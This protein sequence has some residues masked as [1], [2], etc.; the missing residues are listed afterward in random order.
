MA[1]LNPQNEQFDRTSGVTTPYWID[2][3]EAKFTAKP[4]SENMKVDVCIVGGGIAGIT[5]AYLL[6]KAG[7]RV[8]LLEDGQIG[9][10]ETG[11]TTA[12][13]SSVI[14]SGF[15][16]IKRIHGL[17]K[18]RLAAQSHAEAINTIE[19]IVREEHIDCEFKRVDGY[20]FQDKSQPSHLLQEEF[21]AA[22][23]ADMKDAQLI[24][25]IP[26]PDFAT[27]SAIHFP[28]QAQFHPM[29][30]LDALAHVVTDT[31]KAA[32]YTNTRALELSE[33]QGL[34]HVTTNTGHTVTAKDVIVAT[35]TPVFDKL[36]IH[37]KQAAYRSYVIAVHIPHGYVSAA[38]YW[39]NAE[40]YHYVR[41]QEGS[42]ESDDILI[43]GGEDH[44]TGEVF[45]ANERYDRLEQWTKERF[46]QAKEVAWKWSGQIMESIDGLAFLGKQPGK[47][48]NVYIVTGDSGM[49]LTHSTI[50]A[51]INSNYILGKEN[52]WADIYSPSRISLGAAKTYVTE[53]IKTAKG[54]ADLLHKAKGSAEEALP[55]NEGVIAEK[56][57]KKV[58]MYKDKD[59]NIHQRSAICTHL[60]CAVRWNGD[61]KTWDCPCHGSRFSPT[62]T[63]VNGPA[64]KDLKAI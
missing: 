51:I 38:L 23:D 48:D 2:A 37:T 36:K 11:R 22:H 61:E 8:V 26:L 59:G 10:G 34:L 45:D 52:P 41:I 39:D 7:K 6:A 42:H 64:N 28:G 47:P 30:Y 43:V 55:L 63:V 56:N 44:K 3:Y 4:L 16:E 54:Y 53:N 29:K 1:S 15:T 49:G 18:L 33:H 27:G 14:D 20:L 57:G 32:I 31:Y 25:Q 21:Q 13:L 50:G 58:A 19:R 40:P 9:S 17:D 5:S 24:D 62:G 46:P 35:N 12:H 60:G